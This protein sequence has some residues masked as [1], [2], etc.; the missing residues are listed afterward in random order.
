MRL[1][2]T[3]ISDAPPVPV[4]LDLPADVHRDLTFY[5]ELL[6]HASGQ[7]PVD[8]ARLIAPMLERFMR[9]DRAFNKARNVGPGFGPD[10]APFV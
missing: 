1:R 2:I 6:S 5:A 10:P 7:P 9:S 4:T 8:P 3:P